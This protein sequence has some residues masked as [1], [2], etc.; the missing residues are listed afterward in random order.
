MG[1]FVDQLLPVV[2]SS[3]TT[4]ERV[5]FLSLIFQI[6]RLT[7]AIKSVCGTSLVNVPGI[8]NY[9]V[10]NSISAHSDYYKMIGHILRMVNHGYPYRPSAV[11]T[12]PSD[13]R[14]SDEKDKYYCNDSFT[15]KN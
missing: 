2:S 9:D 3:A 10:S 6:K 7:G 13:F 11:F 14:Q 1:E 8:E 4:L 15:H 5:G 12:I